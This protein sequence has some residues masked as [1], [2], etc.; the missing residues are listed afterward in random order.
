[1]VISK[2]DATQALGEIAAAG[3][4]VR[5]LTA[6]AYTAPYLILWGIAW[7]F[8][9]V[10]TAFWGATPLGDWAWPATALVATVINF[11]IALAMPRGGGKSAA[12]YRWRPLAAAG[13]GML[14]VVALF[15][16][17][18]P[19]NGKQVHTVFALLAGAAYMLM[20]LWLGW[21]LVALGVAV[22]VL[23]LGAFYG[24]PLGVAYLLFM[25]VIV[26][27]G[28]ILGGLWLRKV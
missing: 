8:A 16:I 25:G 15:V 7:M 2:D 20:G 17:V 14:C 6:Y 4:R 3:E 22:T 10:V 26:G 18:E 11:V 28:L 9:D 19:L 1:M 5:S 21:R 23:S 24:L 27:G 12:P 13:I